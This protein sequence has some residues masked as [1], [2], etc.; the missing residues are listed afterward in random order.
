MNDQQ[1]NLLK[2]RFIIH[3]SYSHSK[4]TPLILQNITKTRLVEH[5]CEGYTESREEEELIC[6][7]ICRGGCGKGYCH[8]PNHCICD[9]GYT[10]KHCTQ[11]KS[12]LALKPTKPTIKA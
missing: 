9:L 11:S 3:S 12:S 6:K 7:P 10:G 2:T 8:G 5:C 1:T 4:A